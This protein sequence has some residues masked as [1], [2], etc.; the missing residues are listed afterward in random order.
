MRTI[1]FYRDVYNDI[2]RTSAWEGP[3]RPKAEHR[4]APFL[5][6]AV[7]L[8]AVIVGVTRL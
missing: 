4:L 1:K 7:I 8:M 5:L 2:K 3:Y 6:V